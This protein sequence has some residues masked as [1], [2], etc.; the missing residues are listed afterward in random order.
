VGEAAE[1]AVADRSDL[2]SQV[3]SLRSRLLAETIAGFDCRQRDGATWRVGCVDAFGPNDVADP[4]KEA[5]G[6]AGAVVAV[7]GATDR[8]FLVVAS[9]G[10]VDAGDVVAAVTDEFGGGGGGGPT[11]AQAGG[12]D[13]PPER[14][15]A[16][17]E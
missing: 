17:F 16:F 8:S 13:A 1:A 7:A 9:D 14:L 12:I 6:E 5:V 2:E 15:V 3:Q 4:A 10:S 11:F